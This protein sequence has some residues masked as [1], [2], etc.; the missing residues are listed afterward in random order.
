[1]NSMEVT[2]PMCAE[3]RRAAKRGRTFDQL[4]VA[5]ELP[6]GVVAAHVRGD[7]DHSVKEPPAPME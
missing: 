3:L 6:Y 2:G 4:A 1:M 5:Y 7:C